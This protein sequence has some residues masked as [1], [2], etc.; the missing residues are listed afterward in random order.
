MLF[1]RY[2]REIMADRGRFE[3][4]G[5]GLLCAQGRLELA[6]DPRFRDWMKEQLLGWRKEMSTDQEAKRLARAVA[7]LAPA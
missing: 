7:T 1:I 6:G 5:E 2:H 3:T 4:R